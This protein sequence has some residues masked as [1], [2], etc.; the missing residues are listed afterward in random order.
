MKKKIFGRQFKRDKNERKALFKELMNELVLHESITTT[1]E[2]AQAIRGQIEKL[3]TKIKVKGEAGRQ[4]VQPYL[5]EKAVEKLVKEIAP[6]FSNRPGGYIRILK[7]GRRFSD[8]AA[9]A[10][11]EWVEK[12][13]VEAV[14]GVEKKAAKAKEVVEATVVKE[15]P[16]KKPVAKKAAKKVKKEEK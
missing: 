8:N 6:R 15:K 7:T 2:K 13:V 9:T 4:F 11:I 14:K 12:P 16:V 3:V 1:H 10:I 5:S